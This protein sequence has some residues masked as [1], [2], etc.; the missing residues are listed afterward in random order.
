MP[1]PTRWPERMFSSHSTENRTALEEIA[2]ERGV[3]V[4]A[5]MR[6][7]VNFYLEHR[8]TEEEKETTPAPETKPRARRR[9]I[10]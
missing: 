1:S 8:N 9:G 4:S 10:A 6:E 2:N 3:P 7:A 5:V